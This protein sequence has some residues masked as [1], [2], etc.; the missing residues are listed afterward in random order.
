MKQRAIPSIF[1]GRLG[2]CVLLLSLLACCA[3]AARAQASITSRTT[4]G[5]T[6]L[7]IAPGSP[8]GSYPLG[9]FDHV[10]L[11]NQSLGFRLPLVRVGG[12][13]S[14]GY[15]ITLPVE[16]KWRIDSTATNPGASCAGCELFFTEHR[17]HPNPGWHTGLKPGFGAGVMIVRPAGMGLY[18]M[19]P[20]GETYR[21]TLT[22][23]TFVSPDG[24]EYEFRDTRYGGAP[25]PGTATCG[26]RANR[27]R[28]F[29]TA[30]GS[31]ATFIAD[32][33]VVDREHPIPN[34]ESSV[35]PVSGDLFLRDGTRYRIQDSRVEWMRD[36]N[37]NLVRFLHSVPDSTQTGGYVDKVIDPLGREVVINNTTQ[38]VTYYGFGGTPRTVRVVYGWLSD[39]LRPAN[40]EHGA[41]EQKTF[42]QLFPTIAAGGQADEGAM[43]AEF[44]DRVVSEVV[45]PD[46]RKYEFYYNSYGELARVVL[47]T[48]GA[49]EYDYEPGDGVIDMGVADREANASRYEI[50]RRVMRRR[51]YDAGGRLEGVTT[52]GGCTSPVPGVNSCVQV[53][54]LDPH[55]AP[56]ASPCA[57]PGETGYRLVSRSKHHYHGVPGP[58]LFTEPTHYARWDEGR[59]F[60]TETFAC[61]GTT[62]LRNVSQ[63]WR[64]REQ[65]GWW[66]NF[67][68]NERGP[69]PGNDPRLVETSTTLADTGQV[70]KQTAVDPADPASVGFDR[71]NNPTDLW[72]YDFGAPGTNLP[73]ALLRRTHT[74]Y[75]TEAEY[76]G[77][78]PD[79]PMQGA[80]L[81]GLPLKRWVS[82]DA[83]GASKVSLAEYEYDNYAPDPQQ[84]HAA[85]LPRNSITNL[86]L[87]LGAGGACA[88]ASDTD[89]KRRGNVTGVTS[90]ADAA[91]ETGAVTASSQYDAAGN[92]V[93]T[94]DARGYASTVDYEDRFGLPDAEAQGNTAPPSLSTGS[95]FAFPT[96]VTN[97]LGHTS[98][99]QYDYH[100]GLVVNTEDANGT[101]GLVRYDDLLDR[102]TQ[103]VRAENVPAL[104]SQTTF[105][106]DDAG[107]KITTTNDQTAFGDN[108][109]KGEALYDGLGRTVEWRRYVGGG[110]Y[111]ATLIK[112]DALSRMAEV[113]NPH[114]PLAVPAEA[115]VWT[116]TS[117][118]A[119]RRVVS[120]ETPDG[121]KVQ[122]AYH[123]ARALVTDQA[124]KQRLSVTDALGQLSDVWEIR[125]QDAETGT[126]GV[127]FP[128]PQ[129]VPAVSAGYRTSYRYDA[130]GNLRTVEQGPQRRHFFYDSLGR[131]LRAKNSEQ[132]TRAPLALDPSLV[133]ATD[134]NTWSLA[135]EYDENGNLKR[136]EDARGVVTDYVYDAL[137]RVTNRNYSDVTPDVTYVYELAGIANSVGRL[138]SVDS[139]V[140]VSRFT[141]YDELGQV[142]ASTQETAGQLPYEMS[143]GYH[144]DG[145][146]ESQVYPSGRVVK[147]EYD[148]GGRLAGV[149][150]AGDSYYAG[151]NPSV[152]NNPEV[153]KYTA[154]GAVSTMKLGNGRWEHTNFNNRL[155]PVEIGLGTEA[156]DSSILQ[157][158]YTY[159]VR[160]GGV[161]DIS[162]NSG[163]VEGQTII[164]PGLE[165]KQ[166]YVYDALNRLHSAR[167]V[168]EA[169]PCPLNTVQTADCW[170]QTYSYDRFGNRRFQADQ[171]TTPSITT[172]NEN[173]ANPAISVSDNQFSST[174]YR[175]DAAGNL[176]CD[177][178]HP[179]GLSSPY[180]AYYTYDAENRLRT[181]GGEAS[182]EGG[183]T[184]TYDGDGRRVQKMV[185]LAKTIFVY[186]ATGKLVAEYTNTTP[187]HN[188]T[189]Y[190]TADHLGSPRIVTD[191]TG[192]VKG[193]HDYLPYGEEIGAG[194]G[195][196][197][198]SQGYSQFDGVRQKFGGHERDAETSLDYMKA[199][200]FSSAQGRFTSVDPVGLTFSRLIDPQ[201]FNRYS[202][203]RNNPLKYVDP[204]GRDLKLKAGMKKADADRIMKINVSIYR[205]ASGRAAL[206]KMESS[207]IPITSGSG[208][209]PTKITQV[210]TKTN[211]DEQYG[212]TSRE[213]T[214][215]PAP[216]EKLKTVVLT[217]ITVTYD[218]EKRDAAQTR[219]MNDPRFANAA[220]D[221]QQHVGNH[222]TGH[223][224]ALITD[225]VKEVTA[226]EEESEAYAEDFAKKIEK[227]PN[228]MKEKD[229][230][231][232][233]KEMFGYDNYEFADKKKKKN[234]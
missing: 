88:Q 89:F 100:A 115:A 96:K 21:K 208:N 163:N 187:A 6:P 40:A 133:S 4:D 41:E 226:T 71:Y 109:L 116:R 15:T 181:A 85:L 69:E 156:A 63:A 34:P 204:D 111:I 83:A 146:L 221:S 123:G 31:A 210:G 218:F 216:P 195:G 97:A 125:G 161:L 168:N 20:C 152:A 144:L 61:D 233:V 99:T 10:S 57:Q 56:G 201:Q 93:K 234:D 98:R 122:T 140:S 50:F 129:G 82:S 90:Y 178:A 102:P 35:I 155:Q 112:Y 132:D 8:A 14:A 222:E 114:R 60:K 119:L 229:A 75:K 215:Y 165:L 172:G 134:N 126:E 52:F 81:R 72:E 211:I 30:D 135:Y 176:E 206:E 23:L 150:K 130:P 3:A 16:R 18:S 184:Y 174:G 180:P 164:A 227:E 148:G 207:A 110:Q 108:R 26:V 32:S 17:Y 167:E 124:G 205:K 65:V 106:Y 199:R 45:L 153:I 198:T 219:S 143:Y 38:E 127:T 80:H 36:R 13:G 77:L 173:S 128:A 24:T 189:Q 87:K 171:T 157:L 175:Y 51:V 76:V 120:V 194:V 5:K 12:R 179:C 105:A 138:T 166:S 230:E 59:E 49:F 177:P 202:Y 33:D 84:R 62:L 74:D 73:G 224:D 232:R 186:D 158:S 228:T 92:V 107:R 139:S 94:V 47:P 142:K 117:Y 160:V 231:K 185:G 43:N 48:G 131:L 192:N 29:V 68:Q 58:G 145:A 159:G 118:D 209:L 149:K 188:G 151:G 104:R 169:A 2:R 22:R 53:D 54:Q 203:V 225:P 91:G 66:A 121:A 42:G 200:Y 220:P 136:R 25:Q 141:Q 137:G 154:H 214:G 64:Q 7:E 217:S 19:A 70:S 147:S 113:S 196:R 103:T 212:L 9:D 191:A 27:G 78:S 197:M 213:G 37:G 182:A 55:P 190:L 39:R 28:E 46:D 183:A 79:S 101:V 193:R 86:C 11:Y 170:K 44:D 67:N 1:T 223:V 162:K 95:T